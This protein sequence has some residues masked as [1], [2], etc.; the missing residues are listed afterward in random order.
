MKTLILKLLALGGMLALVAALWPIFTEAETSLAIIFVV[1]SMV[2]IGIA[3]LAMFSK[4]RWLLWA[5]LGVWPG[6]LAG[7]LVFAGIALLTVKNGTTGWEGVIVG[8]VIILGVFIGSIIGAITGG[9]LGARKT[10]R[11]NSAT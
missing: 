10:R 7:G 2:G 4:K 9:V 5:A 11:A 6:A 1:L 3:A 8:V